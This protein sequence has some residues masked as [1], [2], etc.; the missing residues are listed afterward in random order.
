MAFGIIYF[1]SLALIMVVQCM[2]SA[3]NYPLRGGKFS[4]WQGGIRV[5]AF[6]SGGYLPDKMRGQKTDSYI[7]LTDW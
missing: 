4:D 3:N 6:V 7:H 1:L 5:N 2:D